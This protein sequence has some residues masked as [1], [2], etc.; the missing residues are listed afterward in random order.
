MKGET[1]INHVWSY[2]N[3]FVE[4]REKYG[5]LKQSL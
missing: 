1:T 5:P 3:V 2:K 4:E